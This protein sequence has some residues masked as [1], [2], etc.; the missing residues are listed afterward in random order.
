MKYHRYR[1]SFNKWINRKRKWDPLEHEK[2]VRN[3]MTYYHLYI[4]KTKLGEL[5]TNVG[6]ALQLPKINRKTINLKNVCK[7]NLEITEAIGNRNN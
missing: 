5:S 4:M 6:W 3:I 2:K 7:E 1:Y